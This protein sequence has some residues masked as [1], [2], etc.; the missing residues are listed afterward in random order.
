[1]KSSLATA[2]R[3]GAGRTTLAVLCLALTACGSGSA[4]ATGRVAARVG[5]IEIIDPY[6]PNPAS[7][8]VAAVYLTVRNTGSTPDALVGASS[9]IA[10]SATLHTE[11]VQG[12]YEAMVPL[13]RLGVSAHGQA[14]LVP[15]HDHVMLEGLN[16]A[17]KVGQTVTVTLR[18]ANAG[19]VAV[20]VL[21]VPLD[22][23]VNGMANMPGMRGT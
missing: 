4:A 23:V 20:P 18:F 5:E 16:Q 12:S 15:G 22:S 14:S 11:I 10:A 3:T 6:L 13:V 2:W 17:L 1:V 21:V 9:A 19:Q 7:P 8:S